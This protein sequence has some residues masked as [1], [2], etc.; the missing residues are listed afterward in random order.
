MLPR[1]TWIDIGPID[2]EFRWV[3]MLRSVARRSSLSA[4]S[5]LN[6]DRLQAGDIKL[7][8]DMGAWSDF[9]SDGNI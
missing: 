6:V 3:E 5:E 4:P 2:I 8:A 1:G 7:L 9:K